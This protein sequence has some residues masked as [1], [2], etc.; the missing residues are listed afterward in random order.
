MGD[1]SHS[2]HNVNQLTKLTSVEVENL[3]RPIMRKE[4]EWVTKTPKERKS[5]NQIVFNDTCYQILKGK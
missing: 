5:Q 2:N 3:S 4:I 1:I